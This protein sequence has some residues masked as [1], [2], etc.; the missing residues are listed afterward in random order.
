MQQMRFHWAQKGTTTSFL[1]PAGKLALCLGTEHTK[2]KP[3]L[4]S[5]QDFIVKSRL[6][7]PQESL[8]KKAHAHKP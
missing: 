5:T 3:L 7:G 2:I 6:V 8:N 4:R 1:S